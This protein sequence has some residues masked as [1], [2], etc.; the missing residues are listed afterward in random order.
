MPYLQSFVKPDDVWVAELSQDP[1]LP[2]QVLATIF[3]FYLTGINYLNC[4][5]FHKIQE[6]WFFSQMMC[7]W[8]IAKL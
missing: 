7:T 4:N 2:V 3:I 6:K 5:L 1:R 8:Y